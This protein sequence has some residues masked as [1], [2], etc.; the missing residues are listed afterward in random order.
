VEVLL[1]RKK[2]VGKAMESD[3]LQWIAMLRASGNL[4]EGETLKMEDGPGVLR[5]MGDRE[6]GYWMISFEGVDELAE[7]WEAGEMPLPP[8]IRRER[9]RRGMP[10]REPGL[11]E[12]RYQ[13]VFAERP[14]AVAAPTAGLHFTPDLLSRIEAKGVEVCTLSLLVG[15]GTFR[16]VRT[17]RVEDHSIEAEFYHLP[18]TTAEAV[19]R[20]LAEDRRVVTTG[21]TCCRVLEYVV[22]EEL[23]EEHSGWTDLYIYPPFDYRVVGALITNFHLPKSSLLMLVSAFAG[24]EQVLNA[25][26]EAVQEGYR[27]YSYGDATFLF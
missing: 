4:R 16:P 27:F 17:D 22:R 12:E 15:P 23:W 20:A 14:G 6:D 8:Y 19:E 9:K 1:V 26:E 13:T 10:E 3:D 24:R 7:V 18:E 21:T 2:D 25:Y 11:D 5:L